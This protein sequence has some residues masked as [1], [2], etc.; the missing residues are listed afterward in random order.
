MK[1][2]LHTHSNYSLDGEFAVQYLIDFFKKNNF[3]IIS[4]TDH[5]TCEAYKHIEEDNNIK[6]ITGMEADA[7]VNNHTY[8]FLCYNFQIDE[9]YKYAKE[10]YES[11]DKRQEKI[12]KALVEKAKENNINLIGIDTFDSNKEYAH[13]AIFRM[14]EEDFLQKNNIR[15]TSDLYRISTINPSFPLYIDMHIVWPDIKELVEIIHKNNGKIFLA[16]PYRYN[17]NVIEVLDEVKNYVDGIE[18][19]NNPNSEEEV[20][21]LYQYAKNNNLLVSCGS[22]YHG[23]NRFSLNCQYLNDDMIN[24]ILSWIQPEQNHIYK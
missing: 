7:I 15:S 9:V 13:A 17:K 2:N 21:F 8:D 12:F 6:I 1:I 18:I 16:H 5:D 4:I 10:K 19:C 20:M 14:L 22:D 23:N 3:D 11:V 24:D